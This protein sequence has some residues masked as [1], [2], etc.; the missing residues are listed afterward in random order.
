M[1]PRKMRWQVKVSRKKIVPPY[2]MGNKLGTLLP[3]QI[4]QGVVLVFGI[5]IFSEYLA[6]QPLDE[7]L[8]LVHIPS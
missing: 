6:P 8:L 5:I 7:A 3:D 4:E 2:F 1:R